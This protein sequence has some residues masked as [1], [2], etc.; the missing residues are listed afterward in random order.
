MNAEQIAVLQK[1]NWQAWVAHASVLHQTALEA[2]KMIDDRNV[3][4]ISDVGGAI[5][6][7]CESCHLQFWYP[8]G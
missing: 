2:I 4:G 3:E 8:E 5:D 1:D 7:A 6:A